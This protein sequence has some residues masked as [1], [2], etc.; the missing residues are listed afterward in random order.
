[1]KTKKITKIICMLLAMAL[2]ATAAPVMGFATD[3]GKITT[4]IANTN[5][6]VKLSF[7][8][9]DGAEGYTVYKMNDEGEF[10]VVAELDEL[11]TRFIDTDVV[12]DGLYTYEV[13]VKGNDLTG[14][15]K[16]IRFIDSP[17]FS[18]ENAGTGI[19]VTIEPVEGAISYNV[20]RRVG[21]SGNYE[22]VGAASG[23]S[24]VFFDKTAE[25]GV[26][27]SYIV[28]ANDGKYSS[29]YYTETITAFLAK[30][31]V[32]SNVQTGVKVAYTKVADAT[33][34]TL[35]R[36]TADTDWEVIYSIKPRSYY[37]FVDTTAVSGTEYFYSVE[38]TT[39]DN[40]T[41]CDY[42]GTKT[43]YLEAPTLFLSNDESSVT[44]DYTATPGAVTYKILRKAANAS[45][46]KTIAT[47]DADTL[48][49]V[50]TN[51]VE[52]ESYT[53]AVRACNGGYISYLNGVNIDVAVFSADVDFS[54]FGTVES[55]DIEED[56][57][58]DTADAFVADAV[59]EDAISAAD[60]NAFSILDFIG[61]IVNILD[62]QG[63][64]VLDSFL[65]I[66]SNVVDFVSAIFGLVA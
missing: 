62:F 66:I 15:V 46:Y 61:D 45:S 13:V 5:T 39:A 64:N 16:T 55:F 59:S 12:S 48:S 8:P 41:G 47:V 35:Y 33:G 43:M 25:S 32:L 51:V 2:I 7:T 1:M 49:Y 11:T 21:T 18:L 20:K 14:N 4:S 26:K 57:I 50:D 30:A 37:Y 40:T 52:G 19:K 31:P 9:V 58:V 3:A 56:A 6:G 27:Y 34:Y 22:K 38:V 28:V 42:E 29:Y 17:E 23:D 10:D 44:I 63:M 65:A 54:D 36:R 60:V 24:P 53:Y